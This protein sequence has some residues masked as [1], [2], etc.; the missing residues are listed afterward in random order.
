VGLRTRLLLVVVLGLGL[1]LAASLL[2][3][4]RME[5]QTQ[6]KGAADRAGALL[7]TLSV[8]T[9]LFLTQGR[10]ADLDNLVSELSRRRG[11][12]DLEELVLVDPQGR[13]LAHSDPDRFGDR[14]DLED[15]FVAYAV[16][17]EKPVVERIEGMPRR[18]AVP[19][20]TGIRWA[21]L[22]GTLSEEALAERMRIREQR[23]V[24][25]ALGISLLGLVVLLFFLSTA[26]VAPIRAVG[27]AAHRFAEGDLSARAPVRGGDEIATLA[28]A[29]NAAAERLGSHTAELEQKVRQ[30][31]EELSHKNAALLEAN[32][33]LERLATTDGLTDLYNHRRFQQL[34]AMEVTRQ[35][36]EHKP[37]ALLMMDVDHF[38][39]YNDTHGHPAGD[40][41]LKQLA[42]LLR[43]NTRASD[44]VARY[45]G[46]EFVVLLLDTDVDRALFIGE[47]LRE[48][49]AAHPF[50]HGEG[51]PLGH[52]SVS[53]GLSV[54]P[55]HGTSPEAMI[56]AAD[57]A[58]YGA[59]HAGRDR[60][61]AAHEPGLDR[62][63]A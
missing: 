1:S 56:D 42:R 14:L 54:W 26:V 28:L 3:V 41:V 12:L 47:K 51:Q 15:A 31:T 17:N 25:S 49:V 10:M 16:A 58:L 5:R 19:V 9:A 39:H 4:V 44:V 6:V 53:V 62:P 20:Q 61:I 18:V 40:D 33:R 36:R 22:I 48:L 46:E 35:Q 34:L 52:V 7:Q 63:L 32:Q 21:T 50:P 43:D 27:A 11:S 37:F 55:D 45:G 60:L 57:K 24:A 2:V 59:K 23:L 38:K 13:V 30:R 29:L 8:P